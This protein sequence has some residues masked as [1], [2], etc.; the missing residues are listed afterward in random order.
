MAVELVPYSIDMFGVVR[1]LVLD[2]FVSLVWARPPRFL[3]GA[4]PPHVA[5]SFLLLPL[6]A[7]EPQLI[8]HT[9]N[10][11]EYLLRSGTPGF[12][13]ALLTS[14]VARFS[15]ENKFRSPGYQPPLTSSLHSPTWIGSSTSG[16]GD[17]TCSGHPR[18]VGNVSTAKPRVDDLLAQLVDRSVNLASY[19]F[20]KLD[21]IV[22][23]MPSVA[24]L[25]CLNLLFDPFKTVGV[26]GCTS[27]CNSSRVCR[28]TF[29][30]ECSPSPRIVGC[31]WLS[32]LAKLAIAF[33]P[34]TSLVPS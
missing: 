21:M 11:L 18:L 30:V 9:P 19:L 16:T 17:G 26:T 25:A 12:G 15:P 22:L 3:S 34:N 33:T 13:V 7:A 2:D 1:V 32:A 24:L 6:L 8:L 20:S 23:G 28:T 31:G 14:F 10:V 29:T 4:R 27:I 5:N